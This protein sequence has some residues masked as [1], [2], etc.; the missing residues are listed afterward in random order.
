MEGEIYDS[1]SFKQ[2]LD[3]LNTLK[4]INSKW[5]VTSKGRGLNESEIDQIIAYLTDP[6]ANG[7]WHLR[8]KWNPSNS[9]S[10]YIEKEFDKYI[11]DHK[12]ISITIGKSELKTDFVKDPKNI[13]SVKDKLNNFSFI[14]KLFAYM[15]TFE[16]EKESQLFYKSFLEPSDVLLLEILDFNSLQEK[17]H[18]VFKLFIDKIFYEGMVTEFFSD[19]IFKLSSGNIIVEREKEFISIISLDHDSIIA[20][21]EFL[22]KINQIDNIKL[23]RSF[24]PGELVFKPYIIFLKQI[25][26]KIVE[27]QTLQK[28]IEQAISEFDNERY[29]SCISSIGIMSEDVLVEVYESLF[30]E[31]ANKSLTL[32][33]LFDKIQKNSLDIISP[34]TKEELPSIRDLFQETN[35]LLKEANSK[36]DAEIQ[37]N[38]MKL[39]RKILQYIKDE[40]KS[41]KEIIARALNPEDRFSIF[42]IGVKNNFNELLKNRNAISHRSRIPIGSYEAIKTVYGVITLLLWWYKIKERIGWEG[43]K[44][45]IIRN[46]VDYNKS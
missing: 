2:K 12:E 32:G 7:F 15:N 30:R 5:L 9:I 37:L 10:E 11:K 13:S 40:D 1:Y 44:E 3:I 25:Y 8:A 31:E 43:T 27:G 23:L 6:T 33:Q 20:I 24:S 14:I 26:A 39:I 42:P 46:I 28:F 16:K 21:R 35:Q 22:E 36:P 38:T 4:K 18:D 19:G 45:E 17:Y 34:K 29:S 41:T